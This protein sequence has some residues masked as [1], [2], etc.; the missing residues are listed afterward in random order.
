MNS[1][2][3][4]LICTFNGEAFLEQALNSILKTDHNNF[5]IIVL[6][7]GSN[8]NTQAILERFSSN[9]QIKLFRQE[10]QG[11]GHARNMA[12]RKC[13]MEWIVTLDQDD[14]SYPSRLKQ[15]EETIKNNRDTF[16]IFSHTDIIDENNRVLKKNFVVWDKAGVKIRGKEVFAELIL[17]GC[18]PGSAYC[19]RKETIEKIGGWNSQMTVA[20]D[21]DAFLRLSEVTDFV[22]TQSTDV[23]WRSHQNNTQ[24]RSGRRYSEYRSALKSALQST[25]AKAI[26]GIAIQFKVMKSIVA[27]AVKKLL[28]H[29]EMLIK[30]RFRSSK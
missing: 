2:F 11:L 20:C 12:L 13:Q 21:Y 22:C 8:D 15:Y 17:R 18:F 14:L 9:K 5:E 1:G 30:S 28:R 16:F 6:D 25:H 7:D 19:V 23:A 26:L 10:N 4:F 24:K 29:L 3:S 27:E